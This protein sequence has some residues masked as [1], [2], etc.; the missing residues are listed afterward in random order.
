[1]E[2]Q[3]FNG[4][5]KSDEQTYGEADAAGSLEDVD[6][7]SDAGYLS[8]PTNTI[9]T[10]GLRALIAG[11]V[12]YVAVWAGAV[13]LWRRLVILEIKGREQQLQILGPDYRANHRVARATSKLS[14]SS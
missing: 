8:L 11:L 1:M 14:H 13:F 2:I 9:A 7:A 12:G 6:A 5:L 4:R 10:A 3:L